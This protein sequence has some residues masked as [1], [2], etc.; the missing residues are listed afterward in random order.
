MLAFDWHAPGLPLKSCNYELANNYC[1]TQSVGG[2][3]SKSVL[4]ENI[5]A[6]WLLCMINPSKFSTTEV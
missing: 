3:L 2:L 1:M 6:D 4:A 5:L